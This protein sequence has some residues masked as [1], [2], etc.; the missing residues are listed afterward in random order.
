MV[1]DECPDDES[2]DLQLGHEVLA[3]IIQ[4]APR[5]Q[6]LDEE[7]AWKA[8]GLEGS[9]Q[10][11]AWQES[12]KSGE[13]AAARGTVSI[14][15]EPLDL[16]LALALVPVAQPLPTSTRMCTRAKCLRLRLCHRR[17]PQTPLMR[18]MRMQTVPALVMDSAHTA[19]TPM[20]RSSQTPASSGHTVVTVL[21]T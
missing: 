4:R 3:K 16:D 8:C 2:H 9:E 12:L 5:L 13:P 18:N 20:M 11:K 15:E 1:R 7:E 21:V 19:T 10:A 6:H 14:K 17:S